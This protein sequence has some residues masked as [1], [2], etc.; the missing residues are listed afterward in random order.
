MG[1]TTRASRET[2]FAFN[3][4]APA[5]GPG[6]Y[7]VIMDKNIDTP[8][9]KAPFNTTVDHLKRK[10]PTV[11]GPGTYDPPAAVLG[12]TDS[13]SRLMLDSHKA[14]SSVFVST[15]ARLASTKS[16][17]LATPGYGRLPLDCC[18]LREH[19]G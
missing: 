3:T 4:T 6:A 1:F 10:V 17:A 12:T 11:P 13:A 5:V 7:N 19:R 8:G 15:S 16:T 14:G 18:R 9:I 2:A